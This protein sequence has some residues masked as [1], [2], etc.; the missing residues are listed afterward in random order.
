MARMLPPTISPDTSSSAERAM[1]DRI[2][3][4]LS[5]D[6]T[7]LHSVGM[8]I[9][10][11]KPWAEVDF[12]LVG[13]PGVFCLEVKGGL[14]SRQEGVWYTT[15]LHG[16]RA[17]RRKRLRE[18]PFEQVGS[19]SAQL[20][21]VLQRALPNIAKAI[22]GY[23]VITPDVEWTV[24]GPDID[25]AL[26]YD[27]RDTLAPFS[28]FM[29]R[30]VDRWNDHIGTGWHRRLEALG[31]DEKR[32]IVESIRGDFQLV[33]SLR[34]TAETADRE[35]VRLTEEQCT[36]FARLAANPRVIARGGAG[37]GKTVIAAEEA[38]RLAAAGDK[39]LYTCFSR[40]LATHVARMLID[41]RGITVRTLHSLMSEIVQ[42]AGRSGE[43]PDVDDDD[44]FGLFLPELTLEVL[45]D[46]ETPRYDV[47]VVDEA[48]DLLR[49]EYLDVFEGLLGGQ[50][51]ST[52]WRFFLD[53]NQN[54]FGGIAAPGLDRLRR[55]GAVDWPLTVN[56]RNTAPIATQVSLL[57]G[58][59]LTAMLA[60][61]GPPVDLVWYDTK[62]SQGIV[63]KE[64]LRQLIAHGFSASQVTVLSRHQLSNS[65]VES[66]LGRPVIDISRGRL[67]PE[68]GTVAFSTVS[69]FKGLESDV[70]LLVDVDNLESLDGLASVYVGAS[71]ARLALVVFLSKA[72]RDR[73]HALAREFGRA[74]AADARD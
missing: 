48:Q 73:F 23:A 20:F 24:T 66:G 62:E 52:R 59:P 16:Q 38:R 6:W 22:T 10:D 11:A 34:A 53:P 17:G 44:L 14:I 40:N 61:E 54:L 33:P 28:E 7:A 25:T 13:P 65:V 58:V 35:L 12:V 47:V 5:N 56:C 19:A 15:S 31:R 69:S 42:T 32:T 49:V 4:G 30:V 63:V 9:H 37:T 71:R 8:T 55:S 45:L 67:N 57:S 68:D 26:V 27:Q 41:T 2:R 18:S 50:L 72:Q 70:V 21:H 39:V 64:R 29:E 74:A 51:D 3:D 36:L 60:P 1:F 46:A 43:L